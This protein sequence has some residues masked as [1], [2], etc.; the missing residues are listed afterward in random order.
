[1]SSVIKQLDDVLEQ[2][3]RLREE[4]LTDVNVALRAERLAALYESEARIWSQLFELSTHRLVW[5]AALAA[6]E[7]ARAHARAWWRRAVDE[8]APEV[9]VPVAVAALP[10]VDVAVEV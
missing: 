7:R 6:E 2:Q 8:A 3:I 4:L 10:R 9:L 1:M 5:R